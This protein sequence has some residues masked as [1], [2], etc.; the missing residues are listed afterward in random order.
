MSPIDKYSHVGRAANLSA[1]D[2]PKVYILPLSSEFNEDLLSCT[3]PWHSKADDAVY[4]AQTSP[5]L[6][7]GLVEEHFG[8]SQTKKRKHK[9]GVIQKTG[10][11]PKKHKKGLLQKTGRVP[12]G[13]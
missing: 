12:R 5:E 6:P 9:K 13:D 1:S 8:P 2:F 11:V 3:I 4:F 10:R 7:F